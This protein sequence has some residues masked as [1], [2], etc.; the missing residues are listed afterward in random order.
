M[1]KFSFKYTPAI[2]ILLS[3]VLALSFAGI[4][5]N[6]FNLVNFIESGTTN[7]VIYCIILFLVTVLA[8]IDLSIMVGGK[9]TIKDK[10][11]ITH[12]GLFKSKIDLSDATA[13]ILYKKSNKLVLYYA[14]QKY[15]VI[16]IHESR[17]DDF[18][19]AVRKENKKITFEMENDGEDMFV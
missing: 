10:T 4:G 14:Y 18:V 8:V 11:L 19:A 9:Y 5:L 12:F 17:Y 15:T 1:K 13:V 16:M 7:T 3:V 6:I 2:W